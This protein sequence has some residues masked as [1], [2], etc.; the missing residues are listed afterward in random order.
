MRTDGH[1]VSRNEMV[2]PQLNTESIK[3]WA[4]RTFTK[5]RSAEAVARLVLLS[6]VGIVLAQIFLTY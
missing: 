6:Y 5:E 4:T 1:T 2:A 3:A